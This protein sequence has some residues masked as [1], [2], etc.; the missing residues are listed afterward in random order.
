MPSSHREYGRAHLAYIDPVNPLMKNIQAGSQVWMSHGD[1]ILQLPA[2]FIPIASTSDVPIAGFALKE[3]RPSIQFHPEVYH[4]TE[5]MRL[6][7]NFVVTICGC[8][9]SWTPDSFVETTVLDMKQKLGQDK[10]VLGLSG[11]VDSAVAALLL[12][13]AI[14]RNLHCIFVDNGM[15]RKRNLPPSFIPTGIMV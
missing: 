12:H 7:E 6:L 11:G 15:L 5:G 3:R 13:K 8:H 9:P 2:A 10:V 14:G 4:T 1:T